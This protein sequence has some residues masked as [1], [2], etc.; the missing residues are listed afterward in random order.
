M[1]EKVTPELNVK[2]R[3]PAISG[4]LRV[5]EVRRANVEDLPRL[6]EQ[7]IDETRRAVY[8]AAFE[9][10]VGPRIS[11][12]L[13][14]HIQ[15]YGN[16]CLLATAISVGEGIARSR[17]RAISFDETVLAT[18]ARRLGLLAEGGMIT[19]R[20][21]GREAVM[22]FLQRS[23]DLNLQHVPDR[24]PLVM[25]RICVETV[26]RGD[27]VLLNSGAH[28][29][30]LSGFNKRGD[31]DIVWTVI[32]PLRKAPQQYT[33]ATLAESLVGS[34]LET[35]DYGVS[36]ELVVVSVPKQSTFRVIDIR[37][38]SG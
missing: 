36:G 10:P 2:A 13:H 27:I 14:P 3:R 25:G 30:A 24:D 32:D 16:T 8:Q 28:W 29:V 26:A 33:T 17:G 38:S 22:R 6:R 35:L 37:P 9:I 20:A 18:E 1:T 34:L 23:L 15:Q 12:P 5:A 31:E 19:E 4:Q 11:T 7:K 21:D